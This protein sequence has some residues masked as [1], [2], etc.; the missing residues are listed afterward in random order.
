MFKHTL[1]LAPESEPN[2]PRFRILLIVSILALATVLTPLIVESLSLCYGQWCEILGTR[3]TIRTP[4]LDAVRD[5]IETVRQDFSDHVSSRFQR[6]PWDPKV[7][8]PLIALVMVVAIAL[9]RL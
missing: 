8:L 7:V 5:G 9:L 4:T 3:V 6:V 1:P 2:Q